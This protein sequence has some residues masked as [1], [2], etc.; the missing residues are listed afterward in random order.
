MQ[1]A[2]SIDQ[3]NILLRR[4][5]VLNRIE[6]YSRRVRTIIVLDKLDFKIVSV[7]LKL[8]NSCRSECVRRGKNNTQTIL[9]QIMSELRYASG[10][11]ASINAD[12]TN[13]VWLFSFDF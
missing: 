7:K 8:V 1:T 11:T 13:N 5:C 9:L 2:G 12:E 6:S 10:L 3:N 4:F